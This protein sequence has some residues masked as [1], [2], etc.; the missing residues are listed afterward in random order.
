MGPAIVLSSIIE[1]QDIEDNQ[2]QMK[3]GGLASELITLA[4]TCLCADPGVV[5]HPMVHS[6]HLILDTS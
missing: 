4:E 1:D 6:D 2:T 3:K 5:H